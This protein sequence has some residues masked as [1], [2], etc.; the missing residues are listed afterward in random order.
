METSVGEVRKKKKIIKEIMPE[1]FQICWK[2]ILHIQEAQ[3]TPS[4]INLKWSTDT[5]YY[6]MLKVSN[7]TKEI[8]MSKAL[9]GK[10]IIIDDK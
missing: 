5:I 3:R 7:S 6:K 10:E 1:N 9:M 8:G 4:R 2:I